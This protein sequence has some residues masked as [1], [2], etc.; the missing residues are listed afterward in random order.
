MIIEDLFLK[1]LRFELIK[2]HGLPIFGSFLTTLKSQKTNK[3]G[4][5]KVNISAAIEKANSMINSE[6]ILLSDIFIF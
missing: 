3:I 4:I 5:I 1:N 6:F 2:N